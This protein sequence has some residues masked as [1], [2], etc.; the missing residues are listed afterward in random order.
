MQVTA[1][2]PQ[3]INHRLAVF[4]RECRRK[5]LR[6]TNQ[7]REIF[8][9]VA[10][11]RQHPSAEAVLLSVRRT[12]ANVSLDT[13]YRTLSTLEQMN[14]LTRVGTSSKEHFDGDLR[15]HA[16][17]IC[18]RCGEVYDVFVPQTSNSWE[19]QMLP[20]GKVQHINLQFKGICKRCNR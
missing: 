9:A 18:T 16:H 5:G 1:I 13:V 8:K 14:L 20:C 6:I 19:P 12:L 17:F 4:E 3:E 15:P 11:S 7:R 10:S 2:A